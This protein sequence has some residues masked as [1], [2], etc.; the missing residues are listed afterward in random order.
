MG[1]MNK[2]GKF[3][4]LLL[5]FVMVIFMVGC[6]E[7]KKSTLL[8]SN[9]SSVSSSEVGTSSLEQSTNVS[10][11]EKNLTVMQIQDSIKDSVHLDGVH[12]RKDVTCENCHASSVITPPILLPT[13]EECLKCHGGNYE[14]LAEDLKG[15]DKW[16]TKNPHA[17]AHER[18]SCISCH[19]SHQR[20][21]LT[22]M[23]CHSM[24]PPERFQ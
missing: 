16:K 10:A 13:D 5:L 23:A 19:R 9:N 7:T 15:M 17:S 20:F 14:K 8:P 24:S 11:T 6:G 18:E 3:I 2:K 4:F 12:F 1:V 21:D 22:C